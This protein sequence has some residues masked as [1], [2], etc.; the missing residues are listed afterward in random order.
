M[1]QEMQAG[2]ALDAE[3]A[4]RVFGYEVKLVTE[5]ERRTALAE[6][7][8]ALQ[9]V[10][11]RDWGNGTLIW[12]PLRRYS[13]D[14]GAAMVVFEAMVEMT[15]VGGINADMEDAR[16]EGFV[17]SVRFGFDGAHAIAPLPLAICRAAL[18][19]LGVSK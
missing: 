19:A 13:R 12:S 18:A 11:R 9:D 3:I 6:T 8:Y 2:A 5:E 7:G 15:G 1:S 14:V 17:C 16:G 4:R 10:E